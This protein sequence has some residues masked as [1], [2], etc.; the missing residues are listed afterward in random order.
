MT[1]RLERAIRDTLRYLRNGSAHELADALTELLAEERL[2]LDGVELWPHSEPETW[3]V[4]RP[5]GYIS[6]KGLTLNGEDIVTDWGEVYAT[7]EEAAR[8]VILRRGLP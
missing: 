8:A 5:Y 6:R 2:S 4:V 3:W 1:P 7:A